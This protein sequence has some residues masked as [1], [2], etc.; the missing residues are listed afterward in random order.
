MPLVTKCF[1]SVTSPWNARWRSAF[2][3][4]QSRSLKPL[5]SRL[6]ILSKLCVVEKETKLGRC[7]F[8]GVSIGGVG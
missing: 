4:V 3:G 5:I 6:K 7:G 8:E 2:L 1:S